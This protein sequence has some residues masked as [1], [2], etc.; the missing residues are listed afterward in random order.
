MIWFLLCGV[1]HAQHPIGKMPVVTKSAV[2]S[3][4]PLIVPGLQ[5]LLQEIVPVQPCQNETAPKKLSSKNDLKPKLPTGDVIS[6]KGPLMQETQLK[7]DWQ[8]LSML[9][10]IQ[11][12]RLLMKLMY[13]SFRLRIITSP[14]TAPYL[15]LLSNTLH[16]STVA[17]GSSLVSES[18]T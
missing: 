13:E 12:L 2:S 9:K 10:A 18:H 4:K 16:S 3:Q 8:D 15:W 5:E 6:P 14:P 17:S 11:Y 7:K 1:A